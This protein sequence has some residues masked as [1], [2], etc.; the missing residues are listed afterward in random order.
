MIY[1]D[2]DLCIG[3]QS[4]KKAC[5]FHAN[6][7]NKE[8]RVMDKCTGCVQLR[9]EGKEPACV[10][11]CAGRALH[12]GDINDPESEVSKLL[13]ANEGHVYTLKDDN[14][15]HPSGRVILKNQKWID[16]LPFEF[17]EALHNGMY[18]EPES[19]LAHRIFEDHLKKANVVRTEM[20]KEKEAARAGLYRFLGGLYIME[21]DEETLANMKQMQ[22][23]T[24]CANEELAEA[25]RG[26]EKAIADLNNEDL[27][28]VA[29]DYAK[30]FLAAGEATGVAAFPYE[31]IYTNKKREIGGRT[32]QETL[33]LYA[34]H[35]WE[36]SK[37]M[38]RTMNDHIGLELEFMAVL[39]EEELLSCQTDNADRA[40]M[41]SRD[42]NEF[43][44][45]HLK[46]AG[47]F[48]MDISK[49]AQTAFYQ[50]VG[51]VTNVFLEQEREMLAMGGAIWD[52]A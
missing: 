10:R 33:A 45:K 23:P 11:N 7:F 3:C 49:Y 46:W 1:I 48:C 12:F 41:S 13:A 29:A 9:D 17:E 50:A 21:V 30:T 20:N 26:L 43:L 44:R 47:A 27:E 40:A 2:Q 31:S 24:D 37:D 4:C 6:N 5:P 35:G 25:Y 14:G 18:E 8:L 15:N 38:F 51:K 39:C 22:F 16:M 36:P 42:Q 34:L 28:D 32:E 52:I 19:E